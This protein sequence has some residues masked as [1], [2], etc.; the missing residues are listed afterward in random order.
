MKRPIHYHQSDI[1]E[2]DARPVCFAVNPGV[3]VE[4]FLL[5]LILGMHNLCIDACKLNPSRRV[6]GFKAICLI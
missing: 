2:Y 3:A 6:N 4:E 5:C 1:K